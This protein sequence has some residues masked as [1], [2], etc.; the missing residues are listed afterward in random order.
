MK[1]DVLNTPHSYNNKSQTH[2]RILPNNTSR[3]RFSIPCHFTE[4]SSTARN[5]K[6]TTFARTSLCVLL[7][8]ARFK[9]VDWLFVDSRLIIQVQSSPSPSYFS[10][11]SSSCPWVLSHSV[12]EG[13]SLPRIRSPQPRGGNRTTS[14]RLSCSVWSVLALCQAIRWAE[15]LWR[16]CGLPVHQCFSTLG[17]RPVCGWP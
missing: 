16:D 4:Q 3:R 8:H 13:P 1:E 2:L 7:K 17:S 6:P 9:R 11:L 5:P 14:S 12:Q 15:V 10:Q